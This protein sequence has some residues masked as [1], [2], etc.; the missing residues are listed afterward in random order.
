MFFLL[1]WKML[2]TLV[3]LMW[4]GNFASR[5]RRRPLELRV[6]K[7]TGVKISYGERQIR[8]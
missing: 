6:F 3:A 8:D 2:A 7:F 4:A 5:R 1:L